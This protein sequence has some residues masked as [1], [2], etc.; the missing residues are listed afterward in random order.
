VPYL[1]SVPDPYDTLSPYHTWGPTPVTQKAIVSALKINGPFTD[2][3][4]TRNS[5]GRVGSVDVVGPVATANVLGTKLRIAL[6][7][8]STWFDV[9]VLSLLAPAPNNAVP[10]GASVTLL[11]AVRGVTGVSLEQKPAGQPWTTA[12][13]SIAPSGDGSISLTVSPTATTDYRI[14]TPDVAAG[15][16]RIRVS[17]AVA[18]SAATA[19]AVSGTIRP[20][21][22]SA[23]TISVQTQSANLS[24]SEVAT[25]AANADG[26][27]S[28]PVQIAPGTPY[29]LV[30]TAGQGFAPATTP[31]Q[32]MVG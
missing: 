4:V 27:F 5:T 1:V 30:V 25:G 31:A 3:R 23:P 8:R 32:T 13:A 26:T 12:P 2:M 17:P 16:I 29:R 14:G 21:L 22:P 6:G 10:Y 24:W 28:V 9:G 18:I 19:Q 20:V 7:L 11:G 15:S